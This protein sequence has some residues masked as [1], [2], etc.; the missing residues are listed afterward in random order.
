M[1]TKY[2]LGIFAIILLT[3]SCASKKPTTTAIYS[4]EPIPEEIKEQ[5]GM[6]ENKQDNF[7]E[8][9]INNMTIEQ[10]VGQLFIMDIRRDFEGKKVLEKNNYVD[11]VIDNFHPGGLILFSENISAT[12]QVV[13][14]IEESQIR[15]STPL[16]IAVDEEGGLVARLGKEKNIPTT[17]LPEAW[18][19][20]QTGD[21]QLAYFSGKILGR[22]LASLGFNM[23]MAPVADVNTN[24]QNPVIGKR[25]YSGDAFEAAAM[26]TEAVRGLQ[27]H[28][29][30][31]VI[32]HFPGHGDTS[33]DTH[34]GSVISPHNME[35][36]EQIEF[37]PFIAG[38]DARVDAIMT[39]HVILPKISGD[40]TPAT[41]SYDIITGL[42]R[43][44]L[45]YDGLVITDAM[46]MGAIINNWSSE[47]AAIL[48][49]KAGVDII[50]IPHSKK[51][52]F[53]AVLQAVLTGEISEERINESVRRILLVKNKR[54]LF[55]M[56]RERE[57]LEDVINSFEHKTMKQTIF[58]ALK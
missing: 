27:E 58:S 42:I 16:F 21:T 47:E 54:G 22:E 4:P 11:Y 38:I 15:S 3:T 28:N 40:Y 46:D 5:P 14:L 18:Y 29:I 49:I 39:A 24:P 17:H 26:V 36:L 13:N 37:I 50:L 48:A 1:K 30:S 51:R 10:K 25:T 9:Y 12:E 34:L 52:A 41:M 23:N 45:Q 8:T 32:K 33:G 56:T 31:A 43:N 53:D 55:D 20:G 57:D 44:K 2:F 19:I 35:R 7:L 6:V